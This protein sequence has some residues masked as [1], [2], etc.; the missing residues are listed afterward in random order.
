MYPIFDMG[1][2]YLI[3]VGVIGLLLILEH[4]LINPNDLSKI[5]VA[6]F[7]VNSIISMMLF[8]GVFLDEVI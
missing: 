5:Q 7:N 2:V 3:S 4:R 1:L 6:F 8:L